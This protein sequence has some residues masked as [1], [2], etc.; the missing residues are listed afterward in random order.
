MPNW[1]NC[2]KHAGCIKIS[3]RVKSGLQPAMTP[4]ILWFNS[5]SS[6]NGNQT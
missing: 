3:A 4:L 2:I 5:K 6:E 1:L